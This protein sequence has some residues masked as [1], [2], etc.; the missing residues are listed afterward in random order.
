VFSVG[1][2]SSDAGVSRDA[3]ASTDAGT[4]PDAGS[5]PRYGVSFGYKTITRSASDR[6]FELSEAQ[7]VA[8]AHPLVGRVDSTPG[9]QGQV[10]AWVADALPRNIVPL[11]VLFGT[12]GPL[13]AAQCSAFAGAQATKWK[14]RVRLYEVANEPDLHGWTPEAYTD[15]LKGAYAAIVAADATAI[16]IAG[17]LWKWD[18]GP[19]PKPYVS[20]GVGGTI[21][22]VTRMYAAGAHGHFHALSLHLY[23]DPDTRAPAWNIWDWAFYTTPSVRSVMDANGD[24]AI[25]IYHGIPPDSP[26]FRMAQIQAALDAQ[27]L[28]RVDD[29]INDLKKLV[30]AQVIQ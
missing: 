4:S 19:S 11:L 24:A 28:G 7:A 25:A 3:G 26:Y 22:W 6:G 2:L 27:R 18:G 1:G 29:A 10:D 30:A 17:A 13:T 23:D 5:L 21:E 12:T 8:N 9:N 16:V 15:C 14:G 20:P